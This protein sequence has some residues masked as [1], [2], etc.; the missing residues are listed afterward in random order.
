[1]SRRKMSDGDHAVKRLKQSLADRLGLD[2]VAQLVLDPDE[3]QRIDLVKATVDEL[4]ELESMWESE[5][6]GGRVM[7]RG[8]RNQ[9]VLNPLVGEIRT[10][11]AFLNSLYKGFRWQESATAGMSSSQRG[12]HAA[13]AR[14][15]PD[16]TGIAET[17]RL[18]WG[19]SGP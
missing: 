5:K 4:A 14:H 10:Q 2:G 16:M 18:R 3:L 17:V 13:N 15:N 12:R 6:A 19:T 7:V 9:D 1:M 11:R 8:S